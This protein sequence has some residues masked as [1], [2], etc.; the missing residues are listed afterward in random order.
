MLLTIKD[1]TERLRISRQKL[2]YMRARGEFIP[3][4]KFGRSVRFRSEAF[5]E[6]LA[7]NTRS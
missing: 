3:A 5:Q 1:I 2:T 4:V 7:R 6:W